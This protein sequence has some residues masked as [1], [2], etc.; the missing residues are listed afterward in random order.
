MIII[1]NAPIMATTEIIVHELRQRTGLMRE[2]KD[3]GNDFMVTCPFH[4][5][6]QERKP[7][8][9][10]LKNEHN[11]G[12]RVLEA[13]TVHCYSCGYT[14]SLPKF[15]ADLLG[16]GN[17][18]EGFKWL[19]GRYTYGK[20]SERAISFDF[21]REKQREDA[22]QINT[23]LVETYVHDFKHS[24]KAQA[25]IRNRKISDEITEHFNIGYNKINDSIVI[26][27]YDIDGS[28]K[29]LKE[30]S[31][32]GKKFYN[33]KGIDKASVIFGLYQVM[34]QDQTREQKIW[35]CESEIDALTVWTYGE[36]GIA[37]MGSHLSNAQIALLNKSGVRKLVDGFDKDVAG[38]E[39]WKK[40]KEQLIPK[41]YRTWNTF[42][43]KSWGKDLNELSSEQFTAIKV[44]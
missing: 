28:I 40:A 7:S 23:S 25:Y 4:A 32:E 29:M 33:S 14:A 8:C 43:D 21:E 15:V 44:L 41:G 31:I 22:L 37:I 19:V 34:Q 6:G 18:F 2:L 38:R 30:R 5:N 39:G 1:W 27:I 36:M 3:S 12:D 11:N 42:Y 17:D 13:G 16:L 20:T 9:G 24:D 10:I 35:I 26:P